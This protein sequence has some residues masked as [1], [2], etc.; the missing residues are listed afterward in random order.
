VLLLLQLLLLLLHEVLH[1]TP[2]SSRPLLDDGISRGIVSSKM[3]LP[4]W[5]FTWLVN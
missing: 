5:S 1:T 4:L 3:L 2:C